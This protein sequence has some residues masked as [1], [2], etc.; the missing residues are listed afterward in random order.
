MDWLQ[1]IV[2]IGVIAGFMHYMIGRLD[3]DILRVEQDIKDIHSDMK[4]YR[5]DFQDWMK[6]VTAMQAEQ[7]KRTDQINHR[8]D[9]SYEIIHEVV[10][11]KR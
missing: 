3:R 1:V 7:S 5:K 9:K 11:M 6:H 8:L 10:K 2:I 4:E